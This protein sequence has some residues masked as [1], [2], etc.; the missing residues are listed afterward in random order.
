M[1][2]K[3]PSNQNNVKESSPVEFVR[4]KNILLRLSDRVNLWWGEFTRTRHTNVVEQYDRLADKIINI[5]HNNPNAKIHKK[6]RQLSDLEQVIEMKSKWRNIIWYFIWF[7][8]LPGFILLG[9]PGF[10]IPGNV[11]VKTKMTEFTLIEDYQWTGA[12]NAQQRKP[13]LFS[14]FEYLY[15]PNIPELTLEATGQVLST[16]AEGKAILES[17]AIPSGTRVKAEWDK[18]QKLLTL[19]FLPSHTTVDVKATVRA[20]YLFTGATDFISENLEGS[21]IHQREA[22]LCE[23]EGNCFASRSL[24]VSSPLA[25][26]P[27]IRMY[28]DSEVDLYGFEISQFSFSQLTAQNSLRRRNRCMILSGEY[29]LRGYEQSTP[30]RRGECVKVTSQKGTLSIQLD[31][32]TDDSSSMNVWYQGEIDKIVVGTPDFTTDKSPQIFVWVIS[33]PNIKIIISILSALLAA[34]LVIIRIR[35]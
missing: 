17:L 4:N 22:V 29:W 14:N 24:I 30:L 32:T 8:G 12:I 15:S 7:I 25:T 9:I 18:K 28:I 10:S 6:L 20:E 3:T 31:E 23:F 33:H 5:I 35:K 16:K 13:I 21:I 19:S 26:S 2:S 34:G 27:E 11:D 1:D